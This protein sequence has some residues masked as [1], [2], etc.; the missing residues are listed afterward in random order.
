M[1]NSKNGVRP[2]QYSRHC[3]RDQRAARWRLGDPGT[4][5]NRNRTERNKKHGD[6]VHIC[7][8]P[9]SFVRKTN[10]SRGIKVTNL[11][12]MLDNS[13]TSSKAPGMVRSQILLAVFSPVPSFMLPTDCACL[14]EKTKRGMAGRIAR[15]PPPPAPLFHL[16]AQVI[17]TCGAVLCLLDVLIRS[18]WLLS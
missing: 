14:R 12:P 1:D 16:P 7:Y 10:S 8:Q 17:H 13:E 4:T 3:G 11:W 15:P 6:V 5:N 9:L 18:V 2:T